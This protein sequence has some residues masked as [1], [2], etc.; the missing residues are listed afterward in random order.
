MCR[1]EFKDFLPR[2]IRYT[3]LPR[4]LIRNK[5][6]KSYLKILPK[7]TK[8][9]LGV[10]LVL[11]LMGY[12]PI[13]AI[14]PIQKALVHA[15]FSQEQSIGAEGLSQPFQLPH[16]GYLTTRYSTWHPGI[17]IAAGLGMP[18]RPILKGK[19]VE[20]TY[21]FWGLGHYTVVEHE[22]GYRSTYGH[23]GRIF[24]KAGDEVSTSSTLGEIGLTGKT[25][26]PHTHLE[27]TK[28]GKS[29]DPQ[30]VLPKVSDWATY[31]KAKAG[32]TGGKN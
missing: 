23:M 3:A 1:Q 11:F 20:V 30:I 2:T 21:G 18:V 26:G 7:F 19:V 8:I 4:K 24:V 13:L 29:I 14:P 31:A 12:Q 27:V 32:G 16:P 25:S 15:E 10:S 5:V 17:D 6:L 22:Q 28:S 9:S